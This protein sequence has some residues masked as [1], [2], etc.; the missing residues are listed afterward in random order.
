MCVICHKPEG[1]DLPSDEDIKKMFE[2]NPHGAG[3]AIQAVDNNGKC[4]VHYWKGFMTIETFLKAIHSHG[5][6][7]D[8]RVV[9]HFR[10]KTSGESDAYTTHPFKMSSNFNDL[11][12]LSGKG[13][14]LFHNGVFT[15]LG[16][17]TDPRASDTQDFVIGVA[18]HYLRKAKEPKKIG[19]TI[20]QQIIGPCRVM[21]LYQN[22]DFPYVKFGTWTE[23]TDG[24]EYS[25]MLWNSKPIV[26]ETGYQTYAYG[27]E[28]TN[29]HYHQSPLPKINTSPNCDIDEWGC[30]RAEFAWPSASYP[31]I[32]AGTEK[33][34]RIILNAASSVQETGEGYK[35]CKFHSTGEERWY[36]FPDT[37]DIV[38]FEAID[39][40]TDYQEA[41]NLMWQFGAD[42]DDEVIAFQDEDEAEAFTKSGTQLG[43]Y[44][45]RVA[46][47]VWYFDAVSLEAYTLKGIQQYYKTGEQGH[48]LKYLKE[49]GTADKYL[50]A[51][52]EH[53]SRKYREREEKLMKTVGERTTHSVEGQIVDQDGDTL[54]EDD[55]LESI[56]RAHQEE[57]KKELD[58][59]YGLS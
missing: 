26:Y 59:A 30:N 28:Y 23:H 9:M 38:K 1:V 7:K 34:F 37:F 11:R 45:Y 47:K 42:I 13:S 32:N 2:T 53:D 41:V 6:L 51:E 8:K 18:M 44:E 57:E 21:I 22:K 4:S 54:F 19:L 36:A 27:R 3:F 43:T 20:A 25:N 29:K 35:I 50:V 24:C 56:I 12:K 39:Q 55:D 31:W 14:V 52:I 17:K 33:R 15:G 16:G 5:D 48:V 40:M 49:Y 58:P 10:I 46:G